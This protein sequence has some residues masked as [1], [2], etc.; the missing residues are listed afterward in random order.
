M[1]C[2]Q[3]LM[4]N[5]VISPGTSKKEVHLQENNA[6]IRNLIEELDKEYSGRIAEAL[7]KSIL[8]ILVNGQDVEFLGGPDTKLSDGDRVALSPIVAGG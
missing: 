8:A 5:W 6:T 3:V 4:L 7:S 2:V 1:I